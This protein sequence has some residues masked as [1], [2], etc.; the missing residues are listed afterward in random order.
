MNGYLLTMLAR[1]RHGELTRNARPEEIAAR[2][3]AG[4]RPGGKRPLWR[5]R[6]PLTPARPQ[7]T[8]AAK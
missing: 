5:S 3:R 7:A 6:W 4:A 1:E 2:E 8:A